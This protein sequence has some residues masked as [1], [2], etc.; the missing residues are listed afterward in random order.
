MF[1]LA[2]QG[3]DLC[4]EGFVLTFYQQI[5]HAPQTV[6]Y[7]FLYYLSGLIGGAWN[8]LFG[9]GGILSFRILSI[10]GYLLIIYFTSLTVKKYMQPKLILFAALFVL[11]PYYG[12]TVF[13]HNQ[14]TALLVAISVYFI[15]NGLNAENNYWAVFWGFFF[16]G[17]NIFSR[18]PNVTM[19]GLGLLLFVDNYYEKNRSRLWRNIL[20]GFCG[21]FFGVLSVIF[22]LFLCRHLEIFSQ[23]VISNLLDAG[24]GGGGTHDI[25]TLIQAYLINYKNVYTSLSIFVFTIFFFLYIYSLLKN[26]WLRLFSVIS[27]F[28]IYIL[29]FDL[30][31]EKYYSIIL[32]PLL[33]SCFVDRTDKSFMLLNITSL[34]IMFLLPLGSDLGIRNMG[35]NCIWLGTF[36]SIIHV[37]RYINYQIETRQNYSYRTFGNAFAVLYLV[38]GLFYV[39]HRAYMDD[40]CRLE[41]RYRADNSKFTVFTSRNKADAMNELLSALN[42]YVKK[43]DYLLAFE[44][45]PMIHYLTET[46]PY[47]G[48]SWVRAYTS[49]NFKKHLDQAV[50]TIP[51]PVVLEQKCQPIGGNWTVPDNADKS[52][53]PFIYDLERIKYF[54]A[55]IRDNNYTIV[56]ENNLFAIYTTK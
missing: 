9:F 18:I 25:F 20:Y 23:S 32:F 17:I 24:T 16:V 29:F 45:L 11:L 52:L 3:F 37:I 43:D 33:I 56:W 5:F 55:F 49:G 42:K 39:S 36:V 35:S 44:T 4:D 13:H 40:G 26:K 14:L 12:I 7:Q 53:N 21:L 30:N 1:I 46:K 54:E 2:L 41:K 50:A 48:N 15:L 8:F 34:L 22:I 31:S 27:F 6:E 47:T 28:I 10:I 19:I 38:I 51:L